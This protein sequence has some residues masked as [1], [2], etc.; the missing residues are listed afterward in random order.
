MQRRYSGINQALHWLTV[1]CIVAVLP[2]AWVMANAKEGTA[3]SEALYNWHKTLGS[4]VLALTAFR[5]VW[6]F[7]DKPPAYSR[8]IAGWEKGIT[9]AVYW[10]FFLTLLWM[11]ITGFV[12]TEFD[13]Y[14][15][16]LFNLIQTPQLWPKNDHWGDVFGDLHAL[17][18]WFVYGLIILH[19]AGVVL[20]LIWRRDGVLG[21]MLP[22][23][24]GE[25]PCAELE[26][27]L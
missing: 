7:I 13:G 27:D 21:R 6:R 20:H 5:I 19:V 25:P 8:P 14:P 26:S 23:N 2:L 17:G 12:M 16:K 11:P 10:L 24:S 22:P 1:L 9:H 18:Q 15:T 3:F 4:I